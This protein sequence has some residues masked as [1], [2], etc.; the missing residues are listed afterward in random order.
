M[1]NRKATKKINHIIEMTEFFL[2]GN[3]VINKKDNNSDYFRH[4]YTPEDIL[5][6]IQYS[7]KE[8]L[9]ELNNEELK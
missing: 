4:I 3:G 6:N 7:A 9:K 2:H 5:G 1:S 8:A